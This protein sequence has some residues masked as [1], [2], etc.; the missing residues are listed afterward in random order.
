MHSNHVETNLT[1]PSVYNVKVVN[2]FSHTFRTLYTNIMPCL[3]HNKFHMHV[4][5][6]MLSPLV[7]W[8]W[9]TFIK[10][11]MAI[12]SVSWTV[13]WSLRK[14]PNETMTDKSVCQT[15]Q[16][17]PLTHTEYILTCKRNDSYLLSLSNWFGLFLH[18]DYLI[19]WN[20]IY[21]LQ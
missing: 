14:A 7:V 1:L 3:L 8:N 5:R 4:N 20:D 13:W 15:N 17:Q 10:Q 11:K 6:I 9:P 2:I 19:T 21:P 18:F 16:Q 12:F